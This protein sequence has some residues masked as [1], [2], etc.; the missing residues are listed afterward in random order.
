MKTSKQFQNNAKAFNLYIKENVP[1]TH[2]ATQI[3]NGREWSYKDKL[4]ESLILPSEELKKFKH[5]LF[6]ECRTQLKNNSEE[7]ELYYIERSQLL[8]ESPEGNLI[9]LWKHKNKFTFGPYYGH[10]REVQKIS[11]YIREK[12]YKESGLKEPQQIGV[13]TEKKINDWLK[14]CDE[15]I[16][17]NA[18]LVKV[19]TSKND[20]LMKEVE[21]F[22]KK[23]KGRVSK[24][25]NIIDIDTDN[26][27]VRFT[28]QKDQNYISKQITFK[29]DLNTILELS[30]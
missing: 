21:E 25:Q 23:S 4:N 8:F 6:F 28:V 5:D 12:A 14:Y 30:K 22:I 9:M 29:G 20:D 7:V 19:H 27:R 13:F 16:K 11:H 3:L 26:F 2:T 1:T 24:Y 18:E 17:F 10:Y 15:L